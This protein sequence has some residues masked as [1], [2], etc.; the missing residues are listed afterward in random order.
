MK[1]EDE[2]EILE[3]LYRIIRKCVDAIKRGDNEF[4]YKIYCNMVMKLKEE[5]IPESKIPELSF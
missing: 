1:R 4:E 5:F 3:R 2:E